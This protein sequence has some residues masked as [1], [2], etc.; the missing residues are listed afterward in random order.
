MTVT[1]KEPTPISISVSSTP[2]TEY[3]QGEEFSYTDGV[4]LI[5]YEDGTTKTIAL[6]NAEI[7]GFDNSKIGE[8]TITVKY[9]DLETTMTVTVSPQSV[10]VSSIPNTPDINVWSYNRTIYIENAPDTKYTIIDT[11]GRLITTSK[12]QSTKEEI[13]INKS[14]VVIVVIDNQ[15]FKIAL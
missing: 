8:Q 2:K 4:L 12:T 14:G 5:T 3:L 6:E 9:L 10:P 15:A 13:K 1:V 11:N 7:T